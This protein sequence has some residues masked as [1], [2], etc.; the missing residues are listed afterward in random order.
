M[1]VRV[2]A[3]TLVAGIIV[4][5]VLAEPPLVV[6]TVL[7]LELPV[8]SAPLLAGPPTAVVHWMSAVLVVVLMLLL[9]ELPVESAPVLADPPTAVVRWMRAVLVVVVVLLLLLLLLALPVASDT[10]APSDGI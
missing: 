4:A 6:R 1:E 9:L 10:R 2:T 5:P 7:L 3:V 8:E